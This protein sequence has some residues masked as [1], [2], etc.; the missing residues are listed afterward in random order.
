MQVQ[1]RIKIND[2]SYG[3]YNIMSYFLHVLSMAVGMV[4]LLPDQLLSGTETH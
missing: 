3:F 2:P 1:L 4:T